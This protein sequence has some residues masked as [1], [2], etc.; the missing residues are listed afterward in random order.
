MLRTHQRDQ[1]NLAVYRYLEKSFPEAAKMF[2]L[3]ANVTGHLSTSSKGASTDEDLLVKKWTSTARLQMRNN[4]LEQALSDMRAKLQK[5][6]VSRFKTDMDG[7]PQEPP[8]CVL[9][10]HRK[11]VTCVAF[12]INFQLL[13][14]ASE[15]ATIKIWDIENDG[16]LEKTLKGHTDVI[17]DISFDGA[18]KWL[19]SGSTDTAVKLWSVQDFACERTLHGHDAAVSA[20]RFCVAS[21]DVDCILSC[22]RDKSIKL[23]EVLTGFCTRT[24]QADDWVR[25]VAAPPAGLEE[26]KLFASSGNDHR[27]QVWRYDSPEPVQTLIGHS[28]V[29]ENVIFGTV[30]LLQ[31]LVARDRAPHPVATSYRE[32][33]LRALDGIREAHEE[34]ILEKSGMI[35]FSASRDCSIKMWNAQTGECLTTFNGHEN[36]VRQVLINKSGKWLF[37]CSDDRSIRTWDILAGSCISVVRAAHSQFVTSLSLS[38]HGGLLASASLDCRAKVWE[39]GRKSA[40]DL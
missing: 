29:V 4:E 7:F 14:T 25:S 37:S 22:S 10:G 40:E 3:E 36:W 18:G 9:T 28:H 31:H 1:L 15:D 30:E 33:T 26:V 8:V 24:I 11:A 12:D 5:Y 23:W 38:L 2:A 13:L 16:K 34:N 6:E 20:V 19:A 39:L 17:N 27:V 32:G 21:R 35:L